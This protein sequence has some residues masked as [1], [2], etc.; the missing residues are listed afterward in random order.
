[1]NVHRYTFR[2]LGLLLLV[3]QVVLVVSLLIVTQREASALP[4]APDPA[5]WDLP[6]PDMALTVETGIERAD[7][8]ARSWNENAQLTFVSMQIDWP[9]DDPPITVTSVSPFGWIRFM[10][11]API[12]G[13]ASDYAAL[14]LM[15]ERVSGQLTNASVSEWDTPPPTEP[16]FQGV[17]VSGE[18]ATLA[19]ELS[20][21]TVFRA[22]CPQERSQSGTSISIDPLTGD[23]IWN[24]VYRD[25]SEAAGGP[26]RISVNAESGDVQ[27]L[28]SG[29][30]TCSA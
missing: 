23:R 9:R 25:N 11:V 30:A 17:T 27:E 24:V 28:R 21:G 29:S 18:T 26:M 12:D 16:L 22:A 15:F 13:A 10:Y 14:S 6:V 8:V 1:M 7:E 3:L 4:A 2:S 19:G 20:G 5:A